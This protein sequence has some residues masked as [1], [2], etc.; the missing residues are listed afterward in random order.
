MKRYVTLLELQL[1]ASR[2]RFV[3]MKRHRCH[4]YDRQYLPTMAK[5]HKLKKRRPDPH[6]PPTASSESR[7][8]ET[9]TI[10][11][12]SSV[13]GVTMANLLAI[14]AYGYS[15][16][17][18]AAQGARSLGAILLVSAAAMGLISLCLLVAVLRFRRTQPPRGFLVYST[19]V[20]AVPIMMLAIKLFQ[21]GF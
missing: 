9:M 18:P 2:S 5:K 17:A 13:T 14:A 10:A 7:T 15:L 16:V 12:T 8:S 4:R 3:T 6:I 21:Q 1:V 19:L 20:A 11:W